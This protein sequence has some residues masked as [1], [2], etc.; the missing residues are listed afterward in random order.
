[1]A[2][3]QNLSQVSSAAIDSRFQNAA[4][5]GIKVLPQT[6]NVHKP[7]PISETLE[8][9]TDEKASHPSPSFK[10]L[11]IAAVLGLL[12]L[13]PSAVPATT[14]P[15]NET[16]SLNTD[17]SSDLS[18]SLDFSEMQRLATPG[19]FDNLTARKSRQAY[20]NK[21]EIIK[22]K[23][24]EFSHLRQ[25]LENLGRK[26]DSYLNRN[27]EPNPTPQEKADTDTKVSTTLKDG[28]SQV[29]L[30]TNEGQVTSTHYQGTWII[31]SGTD[32]L[33]ITENAISLQRGPTVSTLY[34]KGENQ[35][36]FESITITPSQH[37]TF[38]AKQANIET[39]TE[40]IYSGIAGDVKVTE[41]ETFT[42]PEFVMEV[43]PRI[44]FIH[45]HKIISED[46]VSGNKSVQST[47]VDIREDGS[48]RVRSIQG[49]KRQD[50]VLPPAIVLAS[51]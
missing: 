46:A 8:I 16:V 18:K 48:T 15:I 4:P 47:T 22:Q 41:Q 50:T 42:K 37:L 17:H 36:L 34:L 3:I 12:A 38:R 30:T 6:I 9:T 20:E 29:Q 14:A 49:G 25:K 26:A 51:T 40:H 35:G 32:K 31:T 10:K 5:P 39:V 44:I 1:M 13:A 28:F 27:S 45:H 23:A 2:I 43:V 24:E 19:I 21:V 7:S 11:G 33:T